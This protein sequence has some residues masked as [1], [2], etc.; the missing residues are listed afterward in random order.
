MRV[1]P[2]PVSHTRHIK[3]GR[4]AG[5]SLIAGGTQGDYTYVCGNCRDVLWDNVGPDK[6][7]EHSED[8][9]GNFIPV[10]RVRDI[11]VK[12]KGCGSYNEIPAA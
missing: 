6:A 5:S 1:I 8:D 3:T 11:V 2:R 9:E 10:R 4:H 12:C 7:I